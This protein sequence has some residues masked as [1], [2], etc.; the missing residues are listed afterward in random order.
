MAAATAKMECE[1]LEGACA[2]AG[3]RASD[4]PW[5]VSDEEA[6]LCDLRAL[7]GLLYPIT[8]ACQGVNGLCLAI[9]KMPESGHVG[10]VFLSDI[11][12]SD[13]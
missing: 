10:S 8:M 11:R 1:R 13:T 5:T 2:D 6:V 12:S 7:L 4:R 3:N 9:P